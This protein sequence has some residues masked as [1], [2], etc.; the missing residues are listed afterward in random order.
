MNQQEGEEVERGEPAISFQTTLV[1]SI[2]FLTT[3]EH[4]ISIK[5]LQGTGHLNTLLSGTTFTH[6]AKDKGNQ[7]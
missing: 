4:S 1:Q 3:S 7:S 6:H 5:G 2:G